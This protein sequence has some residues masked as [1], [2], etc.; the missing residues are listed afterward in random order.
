MFRASG[1]LWRVCHHPPDA[2]LVRELRERDQ[3]EQQEHFE[4]EQT[5]NKEQEQR[6]LREREMRALRERDQER[7]DE[8]REMR[9]R[10]QLAMKEREKE[11]KEE[12][13]RL[14]T[15]ASEKRARGIEDLNEVIWAEDDDSGLSGAK[16]AG[17]GVD[18]VLE[19]CALLNLESSLR[20]EKT[21]M[22]TV[23]E[24]FNAGAVKALM[25]KFEVFAA[26][27]SLAFAL[28]QFVGAFR[29]LKRSRVQTSKMISVLALQ[30]LSTGIDTKVRAAVVES[31][32]ITYETRV[33]AISDVKKSGDGIAQNSELAGFDMRHMPGI[34]ELFKT[35]SDEEKKKIWSSVCDYVIEKICFSGEK[36]LKLDLA[37]ANIAMFDGSEAMDYDL[38]IA[39]SE[40][41]F[42]IAESWYGK[43]LLDDYHMQEWYQKKCPIRVKAEYDVYVAHEEI[44]ELNMTMNEFKNNLKKMWK[45]AWKKGS[46]GESPLNQ[47][48]D[49]PR[50]L[51]NV[52]QNVLG[53]KTGN[54]HEDSQLKDLELQ[55]R[56]CN[57]TFKFTVQEQE[58]HVR[59][60]FDN[61]P[62][63]CPKH[64]PPKLCFKWRDDGECPFGE[65]CDFDHPVEAKGKGSEY[66]KLAG[67]QKRYPCR[68]FEAGR[69]QQGDKCPFIHVKEDEK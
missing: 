62:T 57:E 30:A 15:T 69:C 34:V 36:M 54:H 10:E 5:E 25:E 39:E 21:G 22:V 13:T 60:G 46:I 2:T 14:R 8:L 52:N 33:S 63:K 17:S 18:P 51:T 66:D 38:F 40:N 28:Q 9:I 35:E 41:L 3:R 64:R 43:Q 58:T 29:A 7:E 1:F 45:R 31:V 42:A 56:V 37:K 44:D 53:V 27:S 11:L 67:K 49:V 6:E 50:A 24:L 48:L 32:S 59:L 65:N 61:R 12:V 20:N 19:L 47:T 26:G 55:C 4:R 16:L 68:F 23:Y